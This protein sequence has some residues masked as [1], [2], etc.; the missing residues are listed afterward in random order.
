MSQRRRKENLRRDALFIGLCLLWN[1]RATHSSLSSAARIDCFDR[2]HRF[3]RQQPFVFSESVDKT[4]RSVCSG[5]VALSTWSTVFVVA[6]HLSAKLAALLFLTFQA[7]APSTTAID[8]PPP[9]RR[10]IDTRTPW[11]LSSSS[12]SSNAQQAPSVT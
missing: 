4:S 5:V 11:M 2:F 8:R 10:S 3:P 7:L 6:L 12:S 1:P 9:Y